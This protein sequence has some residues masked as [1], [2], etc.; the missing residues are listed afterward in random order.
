MKTY[1]KRRFGSQLTPQQ[2]HS[3]AAVGNRPSLS[4]PFEQSNSFHDEHKL[5]VHNTWKCRESCSAGGGRR[6]KPCQW[7]AVDDG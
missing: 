6:V 2:A 5:V 3:L 7:G 4:P 1:M